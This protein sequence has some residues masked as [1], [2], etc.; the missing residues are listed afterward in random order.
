MLPFFP[1]GTLERVENEGEI[2]TAFT[3]ARILSNTPLSRSGPAELVIFDIHALQ[4]SWRSSFAFS[5]SPRPSLPLY[6]HHLCPSTSVHGPEATSP[7]TRP[8][9]HPPPQERFY[10]GDLVQ[11][12]FQSGLPL[13]LR[14]LQNLPDGMNVVVAY[15]DEG[16]WKRFHWQLRAFS[17]G[18]Q[19]VIC[20]KVREGD[21][22]I[23]KLKEGDPKGRHVVIVDDLVQSGSTL[24]ECQKML[25]ERG[26]AKVSAYVTHGVFPEDSWKRFV[27]E[28]GGACFAGSFLYESAAIVCGRVG[29]CHARCRRSALRPPRADGEPTPPVCVRGVQGARRRG[30]RTFGSRTASRRRWRKCRGTR[31]SRCSASPSPSPRR[32]RERRGRAPGGGEGA[33]DAPRRDGGGWLLSL[34]A[35]AG[36]RAAAA[37]AAAAIEVERW[38]PAAA[39]APHS[40]YSTVPRVVAGPPEDASPTTRSCTTLVVQQH[41]SSSSVVA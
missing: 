37:A 6:P 18:Q 2:A 27:P 13:L 16:A 31:P 39:A 10:F 28:K 12:N 4:A 30:S 23:V 36:G 5:P 25:A 9:G 7:R 40:F 14:T 33:E 1:T 22:R 29:A 3:L 32:S 26:A 34:A 41:R 11:P 8:P 35:A 38:R 17:Q 15:P 24:I 21:Q 19:E 20:T